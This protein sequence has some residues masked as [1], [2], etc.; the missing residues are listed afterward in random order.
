M[1]WGI[2]AY[3]IAP[4]AHD[5]PEWQDTEKGP[6]RAGVVFSESYGNLQ[7]VPEIHRYLGQGQLQAPYHMFV[8]GNLRNCWVQSFR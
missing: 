7:A 6:H 8:T 4:T 1:E 5:R 2:E 3:L